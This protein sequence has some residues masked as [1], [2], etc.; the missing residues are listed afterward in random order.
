VLIMSAVNRVDA[1]AMEVLNDINRDLLEQSIRFHLA[2]VKGPVQDRLINSPLWRSL[3][4]TVYLSVN[5][6]YEAL[7]AQRPQLDGAWA[8]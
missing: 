5:A 6:A 3:S 1:T 2:E 4:G 8:V 7:D